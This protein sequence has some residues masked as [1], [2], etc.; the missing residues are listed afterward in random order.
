MGNTL[1]S[2]GIANVFVISC[3]GSSLKNY[4]PE[5]INIFSQSGPL[6][7]VLGGISAAAGVNMLFSQL[8]STKAENFLT[9]IN[10][11]MEQLS[12]GAE[13]LSLG[14]YY[15]VHNVRNTIFGVPYEQ[16]TDLKIK[17][18]GADAQ[19]FYVQ[20]TVD[21]FFA[22]LVGSAIPG[23]GEIVFAIDMILNLYISL[24]ESF[25]PAG[26]AYFGIRAQILPIPIYFAL[27]G[28]SSD[29]YPATAVDVS[30][31]LAYSIISSYNTHGSWVP[32]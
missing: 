31:S 27:L 13:F 8:T 28:S 22:E 23:I 19:A 15:Q 21:S 30:A 9:I 26:T 16:Y 3:D 32:Y 12:N 4:V 11:R 1:A 6:D 29:V 10:K 24:I 17:L 18:D 5:N 25:S 14:K 7:A 20:M 2:S